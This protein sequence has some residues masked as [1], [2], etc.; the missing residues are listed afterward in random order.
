LVAH[1]ERRLQHF[2]GHAVDATTWQAE[3]DSKTQLRWTP[4]EIRSRR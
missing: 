3:F 2:A 4:H 1:A